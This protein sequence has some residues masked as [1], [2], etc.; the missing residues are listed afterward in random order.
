MKNSH[1]PPEWL[2]A[3]VTEFIQAIDIEFQRREFGDELARVNQLPLA[4]RCRYVHEITDHALL[5]GVNLDHE[6]VG[7]TR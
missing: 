2:C 6:P 3:D 5:H 4:D 7:V 1:N